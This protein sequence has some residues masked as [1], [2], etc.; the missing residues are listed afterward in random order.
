MLSDNSGNP[1]HVFMGNKFPRFMTCLWAHEKYQ[2]AWK[3][4]AVCPEHRNIKC[5][6]GLE[7]EHVSLGKVTCHASMRI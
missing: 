5:Y 3:S 7:W 2:K 4:T 6:R 1:I